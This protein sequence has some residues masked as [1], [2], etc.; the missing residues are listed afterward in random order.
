M[1]DTLD[2]MI[3]SANLAVPRIEPEEA[4]H[5]IADRNALLVDVRD[6]PELEGGKLKGA[7]NIS[8]GMLEF[9]AD[10]TS[11]YHNPLFEAQRPVILYCASGG[12][13]ALAG[14]TLRDMGYGQVFNLGGFKDAA[15]AG[16]P[17]EPGRVAA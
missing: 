13:A 8:R 3:S 17:A 11:K 2:S 5:L 7:V 12:R 9:R 6:P 4:L 10:P 14:Q 16:F 1:P 15:D